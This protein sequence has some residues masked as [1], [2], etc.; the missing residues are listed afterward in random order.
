MRSAVS[1]GGRDSLTTLSTDWR[2]RMAVRLLGVLFY[3]GESGADD[4]RYSAE[5]R[6]VG[7]AIEVERFCTLALHSLLST[8]LASCCPLCL[9]RPH[10][11][12]ALRHT[13]SDFILCLRWSAFSPHDAINVRRTMPSL[14]QLQLSPAEPFSRQQLFKASDDSLRRIASSVDHRPPHRCQR[15]R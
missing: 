6:L 1:S 10:L 15:T 8:S 7:E 13:C 9:P 4:L 11:R 12:L 5:E 3:D 2:L 14:A